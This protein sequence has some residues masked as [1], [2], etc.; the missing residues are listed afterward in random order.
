M[1]DLQLEVS[2]TEV[3]QTTLI[4]A[5]GDLGPNK[6][7]DF[8]GSHVLECIPELPCAKPTLDERIVARG[9]PRFDGEHKWWEL[10]PLLSWVPA[11]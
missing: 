7:K 3:K 10:H 1:S 8:I 9:I 6:L 4:G 11:P 2:N 5:P